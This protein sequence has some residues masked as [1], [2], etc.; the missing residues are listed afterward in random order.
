M[1]EESLSITEE[2]ELFRLGLLSGYFNLRDAI[3]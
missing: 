2:A 3:K 1:S